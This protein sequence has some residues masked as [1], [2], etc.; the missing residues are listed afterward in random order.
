M[1]PWLAKRRL[2]TLVD[3]LATPPTITTFALP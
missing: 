3:V 1:N 2:P